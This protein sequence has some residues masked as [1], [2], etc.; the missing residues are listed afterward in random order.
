MPQIKFNHLF[1]I[2]LILAGN[3]LYAIGVVIFCFPA[4]LS[5]EAPRD[6]P[7]F[8]ITILES[9]SQVLSWSST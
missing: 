2:G 5:Q 1:R 6:W 3:P 7:Y 4:I 9:P 8:S